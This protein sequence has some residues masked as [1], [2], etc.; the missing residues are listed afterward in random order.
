MRRP[1]IRDTVKRIPL[2]D[3]VKNGRGGRFEI[4]VDITPDAITLCA[5]G[6]KHEQVKGTR[7]YFD[8]R[9]E[10]NPALAT[11]WFGE[12]IARAI[13]QVP[14]RDRITRDD[15]FDTADIILTDPIT[16][17]EAHIQLPEERSKE[18]EEIGLVEYM[19]RYV[20]GSH[21]I[22]EEVSQ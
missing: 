3:R 6:P 11:T 7:E 8:R 15:G 4:K 9:V 18:L 20:R 14:R 22:P 5:Q 2:L 13:R 12:M 1:A 19:Q 17:E 16:G 21:K 10:E